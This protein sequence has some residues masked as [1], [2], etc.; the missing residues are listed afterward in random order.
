LQEAKKRVTE[1]ENEIKT[2]IEKMEKKKQQDDISLELKS[3]FNGVEDI[4]ALN[5]SNDIKLWLSER[6]YS[7]E[8][9]NKTDIV[10][11]YKLSY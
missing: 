11:K 3:H 1:E 8:V 10:I 4:L 6:I 5:K 9:F 2:E 7:I